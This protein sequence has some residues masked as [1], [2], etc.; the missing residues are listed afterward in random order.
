MTSNIKNV[1][2][3]LATAVVLVVAIFFSAPLPAQLQPTEKPFLW[4][5]EGKKP[6][7]L[8]GTI[9]IPD[10]RVIVLHQVVMDALQASDAIYIETP[11][12]TRTIAKLQQASALSDNKTLRDIVPPDLFAKVEK[13]LQS[14]GSRRTGSAHEPAD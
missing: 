14:K 4:K 5:I 2:C 6:S 10:E 11:L 8:F 1:F 13:I 3:R 7:Y 12:D 9:H